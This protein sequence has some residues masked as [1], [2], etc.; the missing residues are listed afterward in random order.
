LKKY[1]KNFDEDDLDAIVDALKSI[2]IKLP[3]I[4]IGGGDNLPRPS[5]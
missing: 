4:N 2:N 5:F 1:A 3:K